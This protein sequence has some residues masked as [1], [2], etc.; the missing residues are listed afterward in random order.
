MIKFG[1]DG[2]RGIISDDFTFANVRVVAQ[3]LADYIKTQS[4]AGSGIVIGYDTRFLSKEY[5]HEAARVLA[6]NGIPVY[7]AARP[8]PTPA[9]SYAVKQVKA[10]GGVMVTAS[11]NPPVYNGIKFKGSFG[12]SA[13][14]HQTR[15]VEQLLGVN[16]AASGAAGGSLI[17][18]FNPLPQYYAH[19][20]TL[21]NLDRIRKSGFKIIA[22]PM[23]GAGAGCFKELLGDSCREIHCE[24]NPSFGGLHP[25]PIEKHLAPLAGAVLQANAQVG[26][27]LDGDADRIGAVD[28]KGRFINAH[29]I[30][31]LLFKYLV[32]IKGWRGGVV[33]TFSTTKMIDKLADK[34]NLPLFETP[35]GFKYICELFLKDDILIGGEESGGLGF[36]HHLPERDGLLSGL[37]LLEM[38]V[39]YEKTPEE[40]VDDLMQE[41]GPHHYHRLDLQL[42]PDQRDK[43]LQ[44]VSTGSCK[45]LA[46]LNSK[47]FRDLD[48]YK[49][50][51]DNGWLLFRFSGTE[52]LLRIYAEAGSPAFVD[53]LLSIAQSMIPKS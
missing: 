3:A 2:W 28:G 4:A 31:A 22:D 45:D 52:P 14:P 44:I 40:L 38:M 37:F 24:Y 20:S 46:A 15:A 29:R 42:T 1:T 8:A 43:L 19:L 26:L 12:G 27:A 13:F 35:I 36:K 47:N 51:F 7:L 41:L 30:F 39:S 5:A 16:P 48:G 25:E 53:Q 50:Y 49:Y 23:Y 34:F 32:E 10:A 17:S 11:H 33:K 6:G 18:S 21:V 9:I